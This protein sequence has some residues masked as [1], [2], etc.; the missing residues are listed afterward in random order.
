[1]RSSQSVP[2]RHCKSSSIIIF[3]LF[4]LFSMLLVM[5]VRLQPVGVF[6]LIKWFNV[7]DLF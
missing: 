1:M 7:E 3:I 4:R 5:H 6:V 2:F